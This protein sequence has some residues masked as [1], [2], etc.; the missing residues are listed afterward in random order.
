MGYKFYDG[1]AHLFCYASGNG[2]LSL[3]WR[4]GDIAANRTV[5]FSQAKRYLAKYKDAAH[6][7]KDNW[8][9]VLISGVPHLVAP[10]RRVGKDT[11]LINGQLYTYSITD[12]KGNH[13]F[14]FVVTFTHPKH[15]ELG[16]I[17][18]NNL[19]IRGEIRFFLENEKELSAQQ[20]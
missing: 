17:E 6:L 12:R 13:I 15:P 2:A 19:S 10:V 18:V 8:E 14:G 11:L 7:R 5:T 16:P 3:A 1:K 9:A 4:K 20:G